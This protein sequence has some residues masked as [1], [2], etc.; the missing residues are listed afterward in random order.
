MKMWIVVTTDNY[1]PDVLE[2]DFDVDKAV[3]YAEWH[4]EEWEHAKKFPG[5]DEPYFNQEEDESMD[6]SV[7]VMGVST[8]W[9]DVI[10]EPQLRTILKDELSREP[11][12]E[13]VS[14]LI[15]DLKDNMDDGER[16][17]RWCIGRLYK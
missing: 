9:T 13:E 11:T 8:K 16:W 5:T 7:T 15:Q 12:Q 1:V 2:P 14:R 10:T 6:K 3:E 4:G 17:I